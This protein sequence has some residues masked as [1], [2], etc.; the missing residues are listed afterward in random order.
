MDGTFE[1]TE[2]KPGETVS[3]IYTLTLMEIPSDEMVI[4]IATIMD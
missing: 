1:L 4:N 3:I 2:I